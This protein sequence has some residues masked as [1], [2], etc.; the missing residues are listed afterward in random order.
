MVKHDLTLRLEK[1]AP[2]THR[3][4]DNNF[5]RLMYWSNNWVPGLYE[6]NEVVRDGAWT[7]VANKDT[8]TRP[9]PQ[10]SG[11]AVSII[12]VPGAH[13]FTNKT[14]AAASYFTGT[15]YTFG[16]PISI[17]GYRYYI[18]DA[19]G[20]FTYE[21]W[22]S[23]GSDVQQLIG[24]S[25]PSRTGWFDIPTSTIALE[26]DVLDL[27][28]VVRA[29]SQP[30]VQTANWD[31]K[32]ENGN[33]D[34][35]NCNFQNSRT[36]LRISTE[37]QN[38]DPVNWLNTVQV[39]GTVSFAG[40]TWTIT[41]VDDR[42][43]HVRFTIQPNQGRPSEDNRDITFTWGA[44]DPVPYVDDADHYNHAW[45][46]GNV[47]GFETT[48]YD[49]ANPPAGNTNAYGV[50]LVADFYNTSPDWDLLS[51]TSLGSGGGG[52]GS[53][54]IG[55]PPGG[56]AN[57]VLTKQTTADYDVAWQAPSGGGG[58]TYGYAGLKVF[59]ANAD[60]GDLLSN[61]YEPLNLWDTLPWIDTAVN[62][63]LDPANGQMQFS[64]EGYWQIKFRA[65]CQWFNPT[66]ATT[67][68]RVRLYNITKSEFKNYN[69]IVIH[70]A[71]RC[72]VVYEDVIKVDADEVGDTWRL[73]W[74][75]F[76][77][78][79]NGFTVNDARLRIDHRWG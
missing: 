53:D 49:P 58:G 7:M 37:D 15:R 65:A 76:S 72:N 20:N 8:E 64:L 17:K 2:L 78:L 51:Y 63:T 22:A 59:D 23:T 3:Q 60:Y 1:G 68:L 10:E 6:A 35:G 43:G 50:D 38:G 48:A 71:D 16:V 44:S 67:T 69:E 28:I 11:T 26:G 66:N 52:G 21:V 70:Q 74:G 4:H 9:A 57:D 30:N 25:V 40:D 39:G 24:A 19:S 41:D 29:V 36:Q 46:S 54:V 79:L 5:D 47:E 18:P 73:E 31:V 56:A 75:S 77:T 32:N 62:C 14:N 13:S 33:P 45:S 27:M 61:T 34:N 12:D 42:G 55:I